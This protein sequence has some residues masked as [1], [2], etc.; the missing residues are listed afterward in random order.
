MIR[1][2]DGF[3]PSHHRLGHEQA[4]RVAEQALQVDALE[5]L[6]RPVII[7]TAAG[8]EHAVQV[9]A[10]EVRR[11]RFAHTLA[12]RKKMRAQTIGSD[13]HRKT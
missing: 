1:L 10:E 5:L 8:V 12:R 9:F 3:D 11:V 7:G 4:R 6:F 2:D 13:L